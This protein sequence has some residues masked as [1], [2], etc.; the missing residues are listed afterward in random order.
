MKYLIVLVLF[1][2]SCSAQWHLQKA[3]EKNP[4]LLQVHEIILDTLIVTDSFYSIDSFTLNEIDTFISD[5]G[6]IKIT[7]YRYKDRFTIKQEVKRDTIHFTK[8]IKCPPSVIQVI[9]S[10]KMKN[11]M[12]FSFLSGA[13]LTLILLFIYYGQKLDNT[14]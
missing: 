12:L 14:K 11:Y 5:T 7:I 2:S 10:Q 6:K 9:N 8:T 13:L 3:I 1:L 4:N